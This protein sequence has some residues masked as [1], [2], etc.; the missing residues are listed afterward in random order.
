MEKNKSM[1]FEGILDSTI[2]EGFGFAKSLAKSKIRQ[3]VQGEQHLTV[4]QNVNYE[5][6]P[7]SFIS[8]DNEVFGGTRKTRKKNK[9]RKMK[10]TGKK[11]RRTGKKLRRT[12]QKMKRTDKKNKKKTGK[13][14]VYN[15]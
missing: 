2:R 15:P 7:P 8:D 9:Y 1:K 5:G 4:D 11:L 3:K 6:Q 13:K 14:R 10:R 12:N